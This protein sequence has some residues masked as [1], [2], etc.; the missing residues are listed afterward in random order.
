L[1]EQTFARHS[2][3]LLTLTPYTSMGLKL[4]EEALL[5]GTAANSFFRQLLDDAKTKI[6]SFN[7]THEEMLA[8]VRERH[9]RA[10]A[11]FENDEK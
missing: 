3:E 1:G 4:L 2:D 9:T 7:R 8:R 5:E 6:D 11:A 10:A